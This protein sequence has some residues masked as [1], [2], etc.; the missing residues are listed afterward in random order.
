MNNV[1]SHSAGVTALHPIGDRDLGWDAVNGSFDQVAQMASAGK[2]GIEDQHIQVVG[3][4]AWEVGIESGQATLAGE[5]TPIRHRV[6]NIY[7][8]ENGA[9]KMVHHH[10]DPSPAMQDLVSRLTPPK[11]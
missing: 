7:Q 10:S 9:W 4:T 8:R 1:W 6:T 3:D 5:K 11:S 2:I